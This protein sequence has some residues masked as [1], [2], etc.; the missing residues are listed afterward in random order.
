LALWRCIAHVATFCFSFPFS[1]SIKVCF[2]TLLLSKK[3]IIIIYLIE[4]SSVEL[5][6]RF[7]KSSRTYDGC[8]VELLNNNMMWWSMCNLCKQFWKMF[9]MFTKDLL[10]C[11]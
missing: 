3:S 6:K 7:V 5:L 1:F 9:A 10:E 4:L 8:N 2:C 11:L